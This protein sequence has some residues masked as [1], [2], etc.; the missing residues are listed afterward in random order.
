[1][2]TASWGHAAYRLVALKEDDTTSFIASSEIV[3]G[4]IKL[5]RRNDVSFSD[6]VHVALV[7]KALG[8]AP[9]AGC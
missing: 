7:A 8:K 5:D 9:S 3:P 1:M 6:I 2:A 4:M